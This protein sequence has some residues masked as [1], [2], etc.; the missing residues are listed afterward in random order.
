[1]TNFDR[2]TASPESLS[3]FWCNNTEC[4]DCTLYDYCD[5]SEECAL[6]DW[7]NSSESD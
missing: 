1:M 4:D 7:L 5:T 6:L 2:I 3:E